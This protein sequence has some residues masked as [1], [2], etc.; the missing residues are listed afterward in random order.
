M[1]SNC[2]VNRVS[3][4]RSQASRAA[5]VSRSLRRAALSAAAVRSWASIF[6]RRACSCCSWAACA[7]RWASLFAKASF[8]AAAW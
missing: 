8:V 6:S 7:S 5:R 1:A 2:C 4:S 3:E